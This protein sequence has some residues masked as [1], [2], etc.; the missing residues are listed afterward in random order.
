MNPI[1]LISKMKQPRFQTKH[2]FNQP[3]RWVTN[4]IQ[5]NLNNVNCV[6]DITKWSYN[7]MKRGHMARLSKNLKSENPTVWIMEQFVP[8]CNLV[9]NVL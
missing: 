2:K 5:G 1:D 8:L 7:T 4:T 6:A 9:R 3:A